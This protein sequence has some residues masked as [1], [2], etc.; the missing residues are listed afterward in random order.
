MCLLTA[1][2]SDRIAFGRR[3]DKIPLLK[4]FTAE[5]FNLTAEP[6]STGKYLKGF[7]YNNVQAEQNG[8][9]VVFCHG[10]GPG[11]IAYTTEIAYFCNLGYKVVALDSKGCNFS[12]G[13]NIK[14]M[15]EGV[16]TATAAVDLAREKFKNSPLYLVGH[17]WG[18]YSALCASS[19]RKV[20]AVVAISAP[21]TP[22]KT[23]QEGAVN[24][25]MPRVLA[26]ILRPCW[27][28]IYL[29]KYGAKGNANAAKRA[30]KNGTPTL[31]IHGDSDKIVSYSKAVFYKADG[32]HIEKLLCKGKKHNPYNTQNAER[33]LAELSANLSKASKL[34]EKVKEYFSEFD[35][36]AATEEDKEVMTEIAEFIN[37]N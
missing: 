32:E 7:I 4:Y 2:I 28:L 37:S 33:L 16:K 11:H 27:W 17:S 21:N 6:V 1:I 23:M 35:F 25:G 15:Y 24:V 18:A 5:D 36:I 34:T 26:A 13:K 8:K 3:Y 20:N 22:S 12:G 29:L 31:L 30:Q 10:M 19:I 14:G 9:V